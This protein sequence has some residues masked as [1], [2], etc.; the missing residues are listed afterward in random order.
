MLSLDINVD[1]IAAEMEGEVENS[2][3]L[4]AMSVGRLAA[5]TNQ[6]VVKLAEKKLHSRL[7]A[8][9]KA[10][11]FKEVGENTWVIE[12]DEKALWIE[13][14][15][16]A[17]SMLDDLLKS[18]KAK[19]SKDGH[20]YIVV[21]F[22]HSKAPQHQTA[23]A[24]SIT[25][26]LRKDLKKQGVNFK[27]LDRNPDGSVREGLVH[28]GNHGG[29]KKPHWTNRALDNVRIYQKGMKNPDGSPSLDGK[30]MQKGSRTAL[31]FRIASEKHRGTKWEQPALEG[32]KIFDE[33]FEWALQQWETE[34]LPMLTGSPEVNPG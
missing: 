31:T 14:G 30:G 7:A 2:R 16:E 3:R 26:M 10:L 34:I 9:K 12:L 1:Q 24:Q 27:K 25:D 22:E 11:S 5:A 6:H 33:A 32:V 18:P 17:G 28:S 29:P 20:K 23:E 4:I 21:P 15:K 19:V 13:D 8:Y